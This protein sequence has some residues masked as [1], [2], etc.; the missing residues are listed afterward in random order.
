MQHPYPVPTNV[1]SQMIFGVNYFDRR[2]VFDFIPK[3][4]DLNVI[5]V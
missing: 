1:T 5:H 4:F 2:P 3:P